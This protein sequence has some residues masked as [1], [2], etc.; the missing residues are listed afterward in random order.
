MIDKDHS[1]GKAGC[2]NDWVTAMKILVTG[3]C[4]FIGSNFV[5]KV[6][7]EHPNDEIINFDLLT[8]AG[9]LDN[10][11]DVEADFAGR[12]HLV[13]GDICDLEKVLPLVAKAEMVVHF[14]A[15]SHVDRS[16]ENAD[17]F[18]RTN[19]VGTQV[20]LEAARR[21][22]GDDSN[23]RFVYVSTDEVYGTLT[24]EDPRKFAENWALNPKSPYSA[25]K[26]SGDLLAQSFH[27]THGLPVIITRSCNNYGPYQFP[28]KLVPLMILNTVS[29]RKLPIYGDGLYVRDWIHVDDACRATDLVL[30]RGEPGQVY[31]I[32]VDDQRTNLEVVH[33]ILNLVA[34]RLG[35]KVDDLE[36][37]I[38]HVADRPGHDRRYAIENTKLV[39]L[40]FSPKLSFEEGL[41]QTVDWY[42]GNP[43]WCARATSGDYLRYYQRMYDGR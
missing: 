35:R 8:Y 15:E 10:L 42:L 12:Y 6:L 17:A 30:R 19:V 4:G 28:E 13:H 43:Q 14:A 18:V 22:W 25:S 9:N 32:G 33:K 11:A 24:L 37:L 26:A 31:N 29:G 34:A 3:G 7:V 40:G 27:H 36:G 38:Q 16:I 23:H 41:Q 39:S 2:I 5:R 20:M 21:N 1:F